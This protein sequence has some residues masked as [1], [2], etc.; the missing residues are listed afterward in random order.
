MSTAH[1]PTVGPAAG[2]GPGVASWYTQG[3]SDGIGDRLL[4]SDDTGTAM[5]LLRFRPE[6][7]LTYGFERALR[8]RV[9]RLDRFRHPAFPRVHAVEY[10]E[11]RDGLALAS[12]HTP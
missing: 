10:L 3:R 4:M 12:T 7:A 5:E 1:T 2:A 8:E 11:Q 6:V 9:E